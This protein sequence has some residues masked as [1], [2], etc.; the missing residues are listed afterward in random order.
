MGGGDTYEELAPL[1]DGGGGGSMPPPQRRPHQKVA[2]EGEGGGGAAGES[3][4]YQEGVTISEGMILKGVSKADSRR[5]LNESM[6][7]YL[8]RLTHLTLNEKNIGHI[9]MLRMTPGVRVLYLYDNVIRRMHAF[10]SLIKLTH[11]YLQNNLIERISGL[12]RLTSLTKLYL[13]GNRISY[14][15]GLERCGRLEE[16][17]VSGQRL[18]PGEELRFN[19]S[20][21]EAVG[22]TLMVLNAAG[23]KVRDPKPLM[24]LL[25]LRRLNLEKCKVES[26]R[27]IEPVLMN[28]RHLQ[29][30]WMV[31]TSRMVHTHPTTFDLINLTKLKSHFTRSRVRALD[32]PS[33]PTETRFHMETT[34]VEPQRKRL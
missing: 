8:A 27:D 19:P 10:D 17:H 30:S 31:H 1:P 34:S 3:D 15:D 14:V 28:C 24:E 7:S 4:D 2:E 26:I 9:D 11:L 5:G 29:A 16:L 32:H 13:D 25:A 21:M 20:C 18:G 23:S 12:E 22:T 6:E 33:K